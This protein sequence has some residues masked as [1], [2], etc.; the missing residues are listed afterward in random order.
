MGEPRSEKLR[1]TDPRSLITE[2]RLK[3]AVTPDQ[4]YFW[5][6]LLELRAIRRWLYAS[7]GGEEDAQ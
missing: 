1:R 6:L 3:N 5:A 4:E 2:E 7:V